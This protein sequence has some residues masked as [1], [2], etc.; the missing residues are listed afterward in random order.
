M[1]RDTWPRL[2]SAEE[3][4]SKGHLAEKKAKGQEVEIHD[5]QKACLL[6]HTV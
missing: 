2:A 4:R 6:I 1:S 3:A 5:R